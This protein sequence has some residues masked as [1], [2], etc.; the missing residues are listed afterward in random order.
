VTNPSEFGI[1]KP[2]I[3]TDIMTHSLTLTNKIGNVVN[4]LAKSRL[5][6]YHLVRDIGQLGY[7]G[8]DIETGITI[9]V[10]LTDLDELTIPDNVLL[11]RCL[12]HLIVA[13]SKTGSF[14]IEY[15]KGFAGSIQSDSI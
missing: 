9:L 2:D 13:S 6:E 4:D 14:E 11:E 12:D 10:K 7:L 8:R 1:K 5:A 3:E 15:H